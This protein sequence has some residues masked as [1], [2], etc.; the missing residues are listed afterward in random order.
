MMVRKRYIGIVIA[1]LIL[2]IA[3]NNRSA[4]MLKVFSAASVSRMSEFRMSDFGY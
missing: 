1:V 3:F 4:I 2:I